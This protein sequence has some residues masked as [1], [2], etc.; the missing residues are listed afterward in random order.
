MT[1]EGITSFSKIKEL[2]IIES[3]YWDKRPAFSWADLGQF[4]GLINV[5]PLYEHVGSALGGP[6]FLKITGSARVFSLKTG[7]MKIGGLRSLR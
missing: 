5:S 6:G 4:E 7:G 3:E 1:I 2:N